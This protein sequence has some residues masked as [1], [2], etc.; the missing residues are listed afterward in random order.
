MTEDTLTA[1][2]VIW[3][4]VS[5]KRPGSTLSEQAPDVRRV[6]ATAALWICFFSCIAVDLQVDHQTYGGAE[7]S[8][9]NAGELADVDDVSLGSYGDGV[10]G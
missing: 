1:L 6:N 5:A 9:R 4:D 2:S 8:S 10:F 7:A 3:L